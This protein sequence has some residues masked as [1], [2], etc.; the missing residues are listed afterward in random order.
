MPKRQGPAAAHQKEE[1]VARPLACFL[2]FA[3]E[4]RQGR[5]N[6]PSCLAPDPG[7]AGA[8]GQSAPLIPCYLISVCITCKAFPLVTQVNKGTSVSQLRVF[9]FSG[10]FSAS[11]SIYFCNTAPRFPDHGWDALRNRLTHGCYPQVHSGFYGN[12][13]QVAQNKARACR[14]LMIP[15]HLQ[16]LFV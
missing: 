9:H 12:R 2:L 15:R 3:E 7:V 10:T 13:H 14:R 11:K 5:G 4:C 6:R 1:N 16:T 8:G